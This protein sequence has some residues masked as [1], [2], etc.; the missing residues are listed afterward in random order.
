MSDNLSTSD[1][2]YQTSKSKHF[3]RYQYP[4]KIIEQNIKIDSVKEDI[5]DQE[6]T[7]LLEE[8]NKYYDKEY[9]NTCEDKN[10]FISH[11]SNNLKLKLNSIINRDEN[12]I[13]GNY[14]L[15]NDSNEENGTILSYKNDKDKYIK[16]KICQKCFHINKIFKIEENIILII[17]IN[18]KRNENDEQNDKK[19]DIDN[20]YTYVFNLKYG[21]ITNE[22]KFRLEIP[23]V[24]ENILLYLLEKNYKKEIRLLFWVGKIIYLYKLEINNDNHNLNS[25]VIIKYTFNLDFEPMLICPIKNIIENKN[26]LEEDIVFNSEYILVLSKENPKICKFIEN[27]KRAKMHILNLEY[28]FVNEQHIILIRERKKYAEQLNNGL[29]AIH[30]ND[31]RTDLFYLSKKCQKKILFLYFII[32]LYLFMHFLEMVENFN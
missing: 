4:L 23:Q 8:Y 9:N 27:K 3:K 6:E 19:K 12:D 14:Y 11:D 25:N 17:L 13:N 28:E 5:E 16:K 22:H 21:I 18:E 20:I 7:I 1:T 10:D 29:I 15:E 32:L 30:L 31:G 24:R 2:T 26:F